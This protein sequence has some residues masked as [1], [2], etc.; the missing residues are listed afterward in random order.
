[1]LVHVIPARMSRAMR[2]LRRIEHRLSYSFVLLLSS[3]GIIIGV[4][5]PLRHPPPRVVVAFF[6]NDDNIQ[7]HPQQHLSGYQRASI[8]H[9][10]RRGQQFRREVFDPSLMIIEIPPLLPLFRRW[11]SYV[12]RL[13]LLLLLLVLML[14]LL[15][16]SQIRTIAIAVIGRCRLCLCEEVVMVII[17][18]ARGGNGHFGQ[19]QGWE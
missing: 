17:A 19:C 1:M 18:T 16:L 8:F 4:I 10:G 2:L 3:R 11:I 7:P 12:A 13:L 15:R 6:G 5:L 9:R 14:L